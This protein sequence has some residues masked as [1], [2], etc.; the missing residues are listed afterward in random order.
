[1][2]TVT[3]T[4]LNQN[5]S[6]VTRLV[7]FEGE[8]VVLRRGAAAYRITR[9]EPESDDP[10]EALVASGLLAPPRATSRPAR[11][12]SVA[13]DTDLGAALDDDRGRLGA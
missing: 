8:V 3:L 12:R 1:M 13:V 7:E 10:V 9:V 2:Q 5:P 4:E 11:H 6:R